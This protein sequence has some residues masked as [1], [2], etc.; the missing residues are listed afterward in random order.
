MF[1][2]CYIESGVIQRSIFFSYAVGA[3]SAGSVV[4]ARLSEDPCVSVLLLEAGGPADPISEIPVAAFLLQNGY[5]DWGYKT[6][7]QKRG[8]HG[9]KN[10]VSVYL[11]NYACNRKYFNSCKCLLCN[12]SKKK[13]IIFIPKHF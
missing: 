8:A 4:A 13:A 7:P 12:F 5:S 9:F 11:F 10:S 1:L 2:L 6:V 3:G